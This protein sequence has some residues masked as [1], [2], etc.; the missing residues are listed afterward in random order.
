MAT[1]RTFGFPEGTVPDGFAVP[2][3]FYDEFMKHNG[4][5]D[6]VQALLDDPDFQNDYDVQEE[7]LADLRDAI[8]DADMPQWML[9]ELADMHASFPE[10]TSIR[11]R[12]STNNEDLPGFSGAGLY[13]SYTHHP[14][15]GHI[16]KSIKQVYAS[17]WNF[18][19]FD[20]RQFYRIDHLHT[21][22]GVLVH[23]NFEDEQANGVGVTTDPIYGRPR[24]PTTSTRRWA[25][26]SSPTPTRSRSRRR[27]S[28]APRRAAATRSC[29]P[30]T[31]SRPASR[32]CRRR[33]STR[34]GRTWA[35]STSEFRGLYGV[36][37]SEAFAM[38]IEYKITSD[39]VLAIKQ[40]R[41]WV[42]DEAEATTG[43]SVFL[44]FAWR[45]AGG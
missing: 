36:R 40:A 34:C 17:L 28:W 10:G 44:P 27:S 24:T 22:M 6:E 35:S 5:Y 37:P 4:F 33:T 13:D 11:C 26:T 29:A 31:R 2:F 9:D 32:S 7:R 19:A 8:E 42:F 12:S 41:P 25:R 38:E 39:G 23:L 20:E 30:P 15:E 45:A 43:S 3:Y 21:A 18:R 14:D 1:L 16:S